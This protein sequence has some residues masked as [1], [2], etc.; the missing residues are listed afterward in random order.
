MDNFKDKKICITSAL[1]YANGSIHIGH[2][3]EYIQTDVFVRFLKLTG[4]DVIYCCADDTHGTPIE[5]NAQK[6]GIKPEE[7]IG[8]IFKE[9]TQD[10]NDFLI[11]FD[12]YYSTNSLENKKF[13][14]HIFNEAKKKG[15]IYQKDI[16]LT[17]CESCKRFLPDRFVKGKCPKCDAP[18]Q[19]GDVCEKCNSTYET[20]ELVE[21]Y[22]TICKATPIRKESKHY[23]FKL[24]EFSEKLKDWLNKNEL[25]QK[26]VKN[27]VM[28][29]IDE[30]LKDWCV[31]RDGPY[32]GFKIPGEENKYFYVWLDAPIGYIA[33]LDNFLAKKGGKAEDYWKSPDSYIMHFIGKDI[34]YFHFLFWPALLMASDFNL[35]QNLRVHGFLTVNKEKMSKSRGTFI[36]ARKY[37]DTLDPEYLRFYFTGNLSSHLTD[38]DM[39]V[40]D[41]KTRINSELIANII[42]LMYRTISFANRNLDS[43]IGRLTEESKEVI[44]QVH[45][46]LE[47]YKQQMLTY[48]FREAI[49]TILHAS[50]IGNK[51]FQDNEPWK[52]D[53]IDKK[54]EIITA[55]TNIVKDIAI[56]LWPVLPKTSDSVLKLLYQKSKTSESDQ[57]DGSSAIPSW[58]KIYDPIEEITLGEIK[59]LLRKIDKIEIFDSQDSAKKE[60]T[61]PEGFGLLNLKVA[62]IIEAK[63]HPD[64][65]KLIILQLDLGTEKRQIVAG[66]REHVDINA[67]PGK[68]IVIV[69]NLEPAKL[70]GEIS[71]GMLLAAEEDGN[72]SLLDPG[73]AES[74]DQVKIDG[75]EPNK[76]NITFK[77]FLKV[78]LSISEEK[79]Y[80]KGSPLKTNVGPVTA[81]NKTEKATIR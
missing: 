32:F 45:E 26:E 39:E 36:T 80:Y 40:G 74:G 30:G 71:N 79:V 17:Y 61:P 78:K 57:D 54:R 22:C 70:R 41:F 34:I 20:I 59:P 9:H 65:D 47:K 66:L 73:E 69:S 19:Y 5:F 81:Q 4:H 2:L 7:L 56:A 48:E 75:I 60:T 51:Y 11:T 16:E 33:S 68:K 14:E 46:Q 43:K 67:L 29:W 52:L 24:S 8:K 55:C 27:F 23:F 28:N 44:S 21:P 50:S 72:L 3:V 62:Q 1:P 10:F 35:P 76:E 15:Y 38:L 58:D 49:K 13:S 77:Q 18:D 37:L 53:D 63:P 42:N 12:N 6:Q 31:S 25:L 64:A